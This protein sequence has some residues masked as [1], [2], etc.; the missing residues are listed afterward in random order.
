MLRLCLQWD[1]L[2]SFLIL[3]LKLFLLLFVLMSLLV[4][5]SFTRSPKEYLTSAYQRLLLAPE[6]TS[7]DL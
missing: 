3:S 4:C 6:A 7:A 5:F 2:M 1:A